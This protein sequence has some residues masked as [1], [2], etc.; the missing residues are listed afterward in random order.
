[1]KLLKGNFIQTR[2]FFII[3]FH[4]L[5]LL[6]GM[7]HCHAS[8]QSLQDKLSAGWKT[9]YS[10]KQ[11]NYATVSLTVFDKQTGKMVFGKNENL[12]LAPASTLKTVTSAVAFASLGQDF[13]FKTE[14]AY[15]GQIIGGV[16]KGDLIIHGSGDPT[17]GSSRFSG[18][19]KVSV[20]QKWLNAIKAAGIIKIEGRVIADDAVWDSQNLPEGWIWED[21]GNYYGASSNVLC[22]GENELEVNFITAMTGEQTA[23]KLPES[24][25]FLQVFNEVKT[26]AAGSG[27]N[28]YGY[29]S[30]YSNVI[31]LRGTYGKD[32]RKTIRFA[33]PD[34]ALALAYDL[35][36]YLSSKGIPNAGYATSRSQAIR[37]GGRHVIATIQSPE[38]TEIINQFNQ[39][40]INLYGEQL[41][42][43]MAV[44]PTASIKGGLEFV[45]DFWGQRGVD[46]YSLN[47]GDGSGLSPANRVTGKSMA[48]ILAWASQQNWYDKYYQSLPTYNGMKM[49]SGT[50]GD[51]L[52]YAGYQGNY[53]FAI[54]VNNYHGSSSAMRSKIF[55]M[56]DQLK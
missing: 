47:I 50:I 28:V 39:K 9:F 44:D 49:K 19:S 48:T 56:L 36:G 12:G 37:E 43:V 29:T 20:L 17:L 45:K 52:A 40:S 13:R 2:Q 1:M 18:T 46:K 23:I 22:W 7:V 3:K 31:W 14:L 33:L 41:L 26:G 54:M 27:D 10:D 25:P 8:A 51:V 4:V 34:P 55:K 16:L 6:L 53:C 38:L 24:Y 11:L 15:R 30:P 42:R 35:A 32:L 5:S 21:M